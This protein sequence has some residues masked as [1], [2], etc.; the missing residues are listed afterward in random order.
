MKEL[1]KKAVFKSVSKNVLFYSLPISVFYITKWQTAG[2][3]EMMIWGEGEGLWGKQSDASAQWSD[4]SSFSF[5]IST[6]KWT[7]GISFIILSFTSRNLIFSFQ[8]NSPLFPF[9][10]QT[11]HHHIWFYI[12]NKNK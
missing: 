3:D 1:F 4:S 12:Q 11:H 10:P 5:Q 8:Y 7:V 6:P 2:G 9:A